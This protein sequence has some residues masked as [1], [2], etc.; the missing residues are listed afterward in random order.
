MKRVVVVGGVLLAC[1]LAVTAAWA[2]PMVLVYPR[3]ESS[4]DTQYLYDYELLRQA[5]EATVPSYGA[6]ELRQ[7]IASMN[8]ARA[9]DEIAAGSGLVNVFARSTTQ[10]HEQRF[11]PIRIPIDKGLISYRVFLI[12][13]DMQSRFAAVNSLDDL[14]GYS[15]GSFPTWADTRILRDGGFKV[16]TGDSY[17]GL[18]R[19]L[20]ARRFDFFSRSA[21]EAYREF[22]ERRELLPDM[23]VEE[24]LLLHFPTTRL[25]FV[26][27]S[28]E[29]QR[30]ADRIEAGLNR[31]IKDGS[32]DAYFLKAK[33]S[34]IERAHLRTR[35]VFRIDN[36]VLSPETQATRKNRPEIWFDPL[37]GK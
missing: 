18:F 30:L 1:W 28:P 24:T 25:F 15:V 36:P 11:L 31:M 23:R 34:L 4:T 17:E 12:R 33:G 16:V 9:G 3:S 10:E 35:K 8:Q 19:M 37:K 14:R 7:S 22:D 20:V 29:G 21:D 32:F 13:Q 6:Y 27:R 2:Q 5:L 26:Q